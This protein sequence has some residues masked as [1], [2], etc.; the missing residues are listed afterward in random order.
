MTKPP[1]R[2]NTAGSA[3][4]QDAM[5]LLAS[6]QVD[7]LAQYLSRGR[8]HRNLTEQQLTERWIEAMK[9][10]ADDPRNHEMRATLN[11]LT[12]EFVMRG[13]EPPHALVR[14]DF[15]RY[16][17]AVAAVIEEIKKENPDKLADI[18]RGLEADV[19]A[20]RAARDKSKN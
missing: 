19:E 11:A 16:R 17:S 15:E 13:S 4:E 7:E 9:R 10:R 3:F 12:C 5:G 14:E 1:T 8:S 2:P 6:Q 18:G 20:F